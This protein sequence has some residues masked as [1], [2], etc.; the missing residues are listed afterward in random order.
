MYSF[1]H[2]PVLRLLPDDVPAAFMRLEPAEQARR[3]RLWLTLY[4]AGFEPIQRRFDLP[5]RIRL[6]PVDQGVVAESCD[7]SS[8]MRGYTCFAVGPK[9]ATEVAMRLYL[10]K[11]TLYSGTSE[12]PW[13]ITLQGDD[14]S[15][16][17]GD[18]SSGGPGIAWVSESSGNWPR[19]MPSWWRGPVCARRRS[20]SMRS[21]RISPSG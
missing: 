10:I 1:R 17:S 15:A 12:I 14:L 6:S 3:G 11:A 5:P 7:G 18:W 8:E 13:E 4:G 2:D 16:D 21:I 20:S 19:H 9:K